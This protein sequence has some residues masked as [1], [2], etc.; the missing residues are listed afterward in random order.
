MRR[1]V[2]GPGETFASPLLGGKT[3]E[4]NP[5]LGIPAP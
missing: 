4:V 5:L 1:G 3:V 2:F